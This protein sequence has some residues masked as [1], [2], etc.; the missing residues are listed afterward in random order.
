MSSRWYE[1]VRLSKK[2][3][4]GWELVRVGWGGAPLVH[5]LSSVSLEV[6]GGCLLPWVRK[7]CAI[8]C[9]CPL[10]MTSDPEKNHKDEHH[11]LMC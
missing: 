9:V 6:L 2:V 10:G 1:T 5:V 4:A 11:L 3:Q 8:H 7:C